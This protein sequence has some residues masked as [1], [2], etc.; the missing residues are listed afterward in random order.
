MLT[1]FAFSLILLAD[2]VK[3][4][5]GWVVVLIGLT[6]GIAAV[7]YPGNRKSP[8]GEEEDPKKKK[9]KK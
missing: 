7:C 2:A 3:V 8:T 1:S 9:K 5:I 6:L 4:A